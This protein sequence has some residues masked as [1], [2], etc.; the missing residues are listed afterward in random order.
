MAHYNPYITGQYNPL[1]YQTKQFLSFFSCS[2]LDWILPLRFFAEHLLIVVVLRSQ[3]PIGKKNCF[4]S[5][6][7]RSTVLE[8]ASCFLPAV[9]QQNPDWQPKLTTWGKAWSLAGSWEFFPITLP[10]FNS[11]SPWKVTKGPNSKPDRLP[12]TI[13]QVLLLM[14][15]KS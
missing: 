2:C 3:N 11:E 4:K 15:Q 9:S 7:Q 8:G 6:C 1:Y 13:F 12:N 5:T 14:V 10:K